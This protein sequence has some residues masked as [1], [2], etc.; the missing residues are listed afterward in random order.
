MGS[1][2]CQ[3]EVDKDE[4]MESIDMVNHP[5]H[6]TDFEDEVIDMMYLIKGADKFIA[7]CELTA[8]K[9]RLRLGK[10][11][12]PLEDLAKAEKY[13]EFKQ[14]VLNGLLPTGIPIDKKRWQL[15]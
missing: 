2:V 1:D 12:D 6:Y 7:H 3:C 15:K 14:N 4:Q 5:P 8:L 10:K 13:M 11:G 9:Y